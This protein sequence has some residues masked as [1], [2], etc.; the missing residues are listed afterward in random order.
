MNLRSLYSATVALAIACCICVGCS[1][2]KDSGGTVAE[3]DI[4][5]VMEAHVDELMA[6][7]GVT[8]VAIGALDDGTPCILILI[9]EESDE[10]LE[11]MPKEIEG[12]PVQTMVT[13]EIKPMDAGQDS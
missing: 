12:H 10:I 6:T 9:Y 13:G 4:N 8:G 11:R 5:D 2:S 1:V 3:R 7:D